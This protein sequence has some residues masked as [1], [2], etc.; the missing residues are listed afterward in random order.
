MLDRSQNFCSNSLAGPRGRFHAL[1]GSV[2]A[3]GLLAT[4]LALQ[5]LTVPGPAPVVSIDTRLLGDDSS[6]V[7]ARLPQTFDAATDD[8]SISTAPVSLIEIPLGS[9]TPEQVTLAN[10]ASAAL[11]FVRELPT[12]Q[13]S[14]VVGAAPSGQGEASGTG[15]GTGERAFFGL[16]PA[17]DRT[18]FVV[19]ASRSMN[20]PHPGP[21]KTR[22]KRVK[23]ELLD[24]IS[25]MQPEQKFFITFFNEFAIPMPANRLMEATPGT[26]D[27]YLR[28]MASVPADGK[29]NPVQALLLALQ[30]QPDTIYLLTDGDIPQKVARIVQ[31]A[32]QQG[33]I[34]HTIGFG[35][36]KGAKTLRE[37]AA[38]NGGSYRFIP[39]TEVLVVK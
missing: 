4:V 25:A 23:L 36:D 24:T 5:S 35:D 29:T 31:Q 16:K 12:A 17:G 10:V 32:N 28:W 2:L 6:P 7:I 27:A 8:S 30:L 37:I 33:V 3:H 26:Q 22:F 11:P 38:Q 18:V 13:L 39:E 15:T 34:I 21:A 14:E 9:A 19:D 20:H 1:L